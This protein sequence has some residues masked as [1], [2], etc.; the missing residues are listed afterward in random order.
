MALNKKQKK[1][2]EVLKTK[3]QKTQQLLTAAKAQPDD[4][5]EAPRLQKIVDDFQAEIDK[6]KNS[7]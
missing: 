3:M 7:E 2:I 1:Q 6:I 5:A 4:P